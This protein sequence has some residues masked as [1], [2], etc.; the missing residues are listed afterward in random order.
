ML[1]K[2]F[3]IIII[4]KERLPERQKGKKI[5][6]IGVIVVIVAILLVSNIKIVPQARSMVIERLG[7]YSSTWEAGIHI[8]IPF[9]DRIVKKVS[10]KE[11]VYDFP[12]Q[13]VI[14]KDNVSMGVDSVV[15]AKIF[16][17]KKYTYGVEDPMLGLQ[18]L[19]ATTLRSVI[20]NME[21][22]T[23]LSSR[24]EINAKM[25][26]TLDKATD[27]WGL[28]VT[29]VELK[30]IT[31]PKEIEEAMTKQMKAERERREAVLQA[32]AHKES[33]VTEAEGD[34]AAKIMA[35]EAERDAA[36]ALAEGKAKSIELVYDAE[37]EGLKKI[38]NAGV[39]DAV[40]RLKSIEA[41]KDVSDGRA[42]KIFIP[43]DLGKSLSSFGVMGEM[44][45]TAPEVKDEVD[46]EDYRKSLVETDT[47]QQ[48]E[49]DAC[50]SNP[51]SNA[52]TLKS[53]E[54]NARNSSEMR[55]ETER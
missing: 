52:T 2:A 8:K 18:N 35:A 10:L 9:I 48:L 39:N 25:Q 46:R 45:G 12:P 51:S 28:K 31:P 17:V 26:E 3:L 19:T 34:K 5:M 23:T 27:E 24:E 38:A 37:A 47:K 55:Q 21:L 42:T 53:V 36:I 30:N 20:G 4:N 16:D 33:V 6:V 54:T 7:Q 22:D 1:H 29:R 11:Q 40:L 44:L 13:K 14:T 50:F 41:M 32:Q 49:K 43:N 15:Y